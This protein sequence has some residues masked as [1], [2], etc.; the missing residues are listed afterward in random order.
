MSASEWYSH[1]SGTPATGAQGAS[2]AMRAEFEAVKNDISAK[3]PDR[4]G[5]GGNIVQVKADA[6]GLEA[7]A[8]TGTGSPVKG[9]APSL[10]GPTVTDYTETV[11]LWTANTAFTIDLSLGTLHRCPTNGATTV[12]L[13]TPAAGKSFGV[14]VEYGGVH[15]LAWAVT[16]G[17]SI[18]WNGGV[19]PTPTSVNGKKDKFKFECTDGVGWDGCSGGANY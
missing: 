4:A 15:T 14:D 7:V 3:L 1:S 10:T 6:S 16:G 12:T 17:S 9:T 19:A 5:N 11:K 18:K 8:A 13:P 2:A